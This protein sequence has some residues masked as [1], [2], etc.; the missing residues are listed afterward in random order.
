MACGIAGLSVAAT[1]APRQLNTAKVKPIR[2]EDGL[3][4]DSKSKANTRSLVDYLRGTTSRRPGR[5]FYERKFKKLHTYRDAI[6]TQSFLTITS[7]VVY[8]ESQHRDGR[9]AGARCSDRA[10]TRCTVVTRKVL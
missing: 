10:L 3:A 5:R 7:N 4:I 2:D 9:R 1:P 8:G 6:P